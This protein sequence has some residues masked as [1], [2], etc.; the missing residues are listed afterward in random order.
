MRLLHL[1]WMSRAEAEHLGLK[2]SAT[3]P[4]LAVFLLVSWQID[5][6]FI[7]YLALFWSPRLLD[8]AAC[9]GTPDRGTRKVQ[10]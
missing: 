8:G 6:R 1:R 5:I 2:A 3:T 10:D 4:L 7:F 9:K